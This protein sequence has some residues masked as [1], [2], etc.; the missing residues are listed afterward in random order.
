MTQRGTQR[1]TGHI[2]THREGHTQRGHTED[3]QRGTH[4]GSVKPECRVLIEEVQQ[5]SRP[6][7]MM[8]MMTMTMTMMMTMMV[9]MVNDDDADDA[10]D[11]DDSDGGHDDDDDDDDDDNDDVTKTVIIDLKP[12]LGRRARA[13][14]PVGHRISQTGRGGEIGEALR[15]LRHLPGCL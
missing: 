8:V 7:M 9:I 1:G 12:A 2:G 10:D 4:R 13:L 11:A 14:P 3:T 6:V 15:V 5:L